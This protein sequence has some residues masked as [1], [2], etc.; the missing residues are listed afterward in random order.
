MI[1]LGFTID[2][3][4]L[5]LSWDKLI[6]YDFIKLKS[7][8]KNVQKIKRQE[9]TS[10]QG[11]Y[12]R[13]CIQY[14]ETWGIKISGSISNFHSGFKYLLPITQLKEAIDR[15]GNELRIFNIERAR[16]HR[17][18]IALNLQTDKPIGLYTHRLFTD[19]PNFKKLEQD[20]GLRFEPRAKMKKNKT[21]VFAIY[22]KGADLQERNEI[23]N[24]FN[25]LRLELRLL[26]R[27]SKQLEISN[28][29]IKDL[30]NGYKVSKL[31]K[32]FYKFY[33]QIKKQTVLKDYSELIKVN[34]TNFKKYLLKY[35][36]D[37]AGG[38]SDVYRLIE[39]LNEE[40]KFK[41][42]NDKSRCRKIIYD[43]SK[44][45]SISKLHP[46]ID[47]IDLK[48]EKECQD[49]INRLKYQVSA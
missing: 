15:L 12:K 11:W 43:L 26:K 44:E 10:Y 24:D 34:P 5:F 46:L 22:N 9:N 45:N 29:E 1:T 38:D 49:L 13:L 14:S 17:I 27:V 3:I 4:K 7:L 6:R 39:Q 20:D 19:L 42:A 2:S 32:L 33:S 30:Y 35:S 25:I 36:I 31:V 40:G 48:V 18:D 28:L 21:I 8:L 23:D 16:I 37:I 41:S 47:E